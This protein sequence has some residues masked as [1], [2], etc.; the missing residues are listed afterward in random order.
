MLS[1]W[2]IYYHVLLIYRVNTVFFLFFLW[3]KQ[4]GRVFH[5]NRLL[6]GKN[7]LKKKKKKVQKSMQS[8]QNWETDSDQI[9]Y[10]DRTEKYLL[11][12]LNNSTCGILAVRLKRLKCVVSN[13]IET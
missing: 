3:G 10:F 4:M 2:C 8:V 11:H 7:S 1:C 9:W 13:Y 12:F 5:G 6:S